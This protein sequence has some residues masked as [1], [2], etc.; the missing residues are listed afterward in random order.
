MCLQVSMTLG[1]LL[2]HSHN[3]DSRFDMSASNATK[4]LEFSVA[5]RSVAAQP[6]L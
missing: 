4:D 1:T 6:Q 2:L 5:L 3:A